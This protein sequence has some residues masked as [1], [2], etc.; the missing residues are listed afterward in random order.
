MGQE[1]MSDWLEYYQE[2]M[3]KA[4]RLLQ[5][6]YYEHKAGLFCGNGGSAAD[7]EHFVGELVKELFLMAEQGDE[8]ALKIY[9]MVGKRFG[10]G[11]A[12]L[13][14]MLNPEMIIVGGVFMRAEKYIRKSMEEELQKEALSCALEC[15]EIVPSML[16]EQIGDYGAVVAAVE[17]L[18]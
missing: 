14:D 17:N 16:R 12:L 5:Q 13:V 18:Q 4:A 3:N 15:V 8:D 9:S 7:C 11:L 6:C 10:R 1:A 2:R